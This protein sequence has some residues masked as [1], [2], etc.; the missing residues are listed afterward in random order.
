[1]PSREEQ[2]GQGVFQAAIQRQHFAG[3]LL[4]PLPLVILEVSLEIV[5]EQIDQRQ[6]G[7]G[8]AMRDREGFQHQTAAVVRAA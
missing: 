1:M 2:I 8:F 3:D 7:I 6:I 4:P 5:L